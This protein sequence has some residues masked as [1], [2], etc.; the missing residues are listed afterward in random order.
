[1]V[2]ASVGLV[3]EADPDVASIT[4]NKTNLPPFTLPERYYEGED[5]DE[6]EQ[7]PGVSSAYFLLRQRPDM[8]ADTI[9]MIQREL[10]RQRQLSRRQSV[11][12][13]AHKL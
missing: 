13:E 6:R 1:M 11:L 5:I 12:N 7:Y 9:T 10:K 2:L 8:I 3:F 4:D